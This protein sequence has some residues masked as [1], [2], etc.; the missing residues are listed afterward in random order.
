ML[1][2]SFDFSEPCFGF[3]GHPKLCSVMDGEGHPVVFLTDI[4]CCIA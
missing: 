4:L 1:V 2:R 3:G